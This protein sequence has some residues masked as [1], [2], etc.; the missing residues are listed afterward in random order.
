MAS[1]PPQP[2]NTNNRIA[3]ID[4]LRGFALLGIVLVNTLGFNSSFFDF[5]GFYSNL[6]DDF[7]S[8]FYSTFI[9][10]TAD[11]FIF[12]YSFLFGYGIYMQ[13]RKFT[14]KGE[15]FTSFFN[16]RMWVLALFGI[17]HVLFLWAGDILILYAL[18]GFFILL[19]HKL[20]SNWQ[21][22]I[23]LFF[24]F[25]LGIW[26]TLGVWI[27]LPDGLSSTCTEC[28]EQAK[29]IYADGNYIDC[30]KLRLEEYFAFRNI[31]AIYYL[32][33][34]LIASSYVSVARILN[35]IALMGKMSLTN[36]IMQSVLLSIIFYIFI[37]I[38]CFT[39]LYIT[40]T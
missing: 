25:F 32:L 10:L 7:Q 26:L 12:L 11:K 9:S 6:P 29:I 2:V 18:A 13:Y 8:R 31:N 14:S 5:G 15:G 37:I 20:S 27:P 38:K 23:A 36:Y 3:S 39:S 24:Y 19:V 1:N 21:I 35:P 17:A 16:R 34:I 28:L 40:P 33:L 30:L 4:I 22:I